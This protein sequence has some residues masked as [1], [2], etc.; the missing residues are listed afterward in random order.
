MENQL[1]PTVPLKIGW[2][3]EAVRQ[4]TGGLKTVYKP[5]LLLS[6]PAS[7]RNMSSIAS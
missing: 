6:S 1:L 4:S 3:R 2:H 5:A 7:G